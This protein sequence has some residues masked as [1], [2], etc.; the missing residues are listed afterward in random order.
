MANVTAATGTYAGKAAL[1]Y[2]TPAIMAADTIVNNWCNLYPNVVG[3]AVLRKMSGAALRARTC[4]FDGG[5][6][7]LGEVVLATT[8]LEIKLQLCNSDLAA[9]WEA[10]MMRDSR[11]APASTSEAMLRYVIAQAAK[12][13]EVGMW[14]GAYNSVD[15]TTS[16]GTS[17]SYLNGWL[18]KIVAATPT[19]EIALTGAT[20]AGA[21]ATGILSRLAALVASAP[22]DIAGDPDAYIY[23]SPAMK[24][25]YYA[26]L[27]SAN[28]SLYLPNEQVSQYA[29]YRIVT[30]RGFA[31]D[32]FLLTKPENLAFGTD[33]TGNDFATAAAVAN[34]N[35]STLE[36]ATRAMIALTAGCQ[37][38]DHASYVVSRR[39]S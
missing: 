19:Y 11:T 14:R 25:L 7:T 17:V 39:T 16:G 1:P 26:A 23:M 18:A 28:G 34:L 6:A 20:D 10:D 12:D 37:I 2:V 29:G 4:G 27:G 30:P 21:T 15:G 13:V 35:D 33:L 5:A 36:D 32:T 31:A 38:I 9:T 8:K 22:P 3:T 24:G